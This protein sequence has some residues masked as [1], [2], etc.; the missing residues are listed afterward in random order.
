MRTI[1][2]RNAFGAQQSPWKMPKRVEIV[3]EVPL[4]QSPQFQGLVGHAIVFEEFGQFSII[5]AAYEIQH[6]VPA[7]PRPVRHAR[8]NLLHAEEICS[9]A[10]D[11][12]S[13]RQL[14]VAALDIAPFNP[15][16]SDRSP[17][18]ED[19]WRSS[20]QASENQC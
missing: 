13:H 4:V 1:A 19:R 20:R 12:N 10:K 9:T 8:G 3:G 7:H 5:P 15:I 11:Y 18:I 6:L 17:I 2:S 16:P 14:S